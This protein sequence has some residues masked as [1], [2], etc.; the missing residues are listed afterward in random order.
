MK[1]VNIICK[2]L[3]MIFLVGISENNTYKIVQNTYYFAYKPI[4]QS[5]L[6]LCVAMFSIYIQPM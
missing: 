1:D 2:K 6:S 3:P 5:Q 4:D